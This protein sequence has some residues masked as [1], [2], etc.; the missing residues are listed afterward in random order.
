GPRGAGW[1]RG[2][3]GGVGGARYG[4]GGQLSAPLG[5]NAAVQA[6]LGVRRLEPDLG[7][8]TTPLTAALGLRFR[9]SR[10]VAA[11]VGY[12]RSPFD[13]TAA[14]IDSG[15]V[16]DA[17]DWSVDI[18]PSPRWSVSAGGGGAWLSDGNHNRRYSAVAAVLARVAPGGRVGPVARVVGDRASGPLGY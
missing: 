5:A 11:G 8:A 1:G 14:L 15:F 18:S 4:A 13:D 17:L 3:V 16:V 2:A 10:D 9:P 7:R 6:G 12:S